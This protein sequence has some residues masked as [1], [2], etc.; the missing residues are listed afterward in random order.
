MRKLTVEITIGQR[1]FYDVGDVS[2]ESSWSFLADTATIV[3]ARRNFPQGSIRN[4]SGSD[5]S[6]KIK[7]GDAVS[8]RLGYDYEFETEFEGYIKAIK[9]NVPLKIEC[10][11]AMWLLKQTSYKKA[12][13]KVSLQELLEFI[14]PPTIQF[15]TFGEVNLGKMRIDGASAYEVLKKVDET[16]KLVS[17]FK[18][19]TL[20]VGFPYQQEAKRVT[21]RKRDHVDV[22]KSTLSYRTADQVKLKIKAIS[23]QPNGSKVEV[24]LGDPEGQLR[25]MH[26]PI[27]LN[28]TEAKKIAEE[29]KKLFKFDGYDGS[30]T[31]YGQP[32]VEHSDIVEIID[33]KYPDQQGAYRVDSVKIRFGAEGYRR[34]LALGSK[35]E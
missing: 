18:K 32:F 26:L 28:E 6:T 7:V 11:D 34:E 2:V 24:E 5:I 9:P 20:Y 4:V 19:G 10:E 8:I 33:Y 16:Y 27:G 30:L 13:R 25:T 3:L 17:Y 23:L 12:W 1:A 22:T 21:I 14:I 35:V 31:T 29:Q 15:E